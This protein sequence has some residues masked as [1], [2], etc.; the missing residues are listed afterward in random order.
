MGVT[1]IM[2]NSPNRGVNYHIFENKGN[3]QVI[4]VYALNSVN[5]GTCTFIFSFSKSII[6][7]TNNNFF[8]FYYRQKTNQLC[9]VFRTFYPELFK[10]HK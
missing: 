9:F 1:R 8:P 3:Y 7:L 6:Y 5:Q 10:H 2:H 4:I